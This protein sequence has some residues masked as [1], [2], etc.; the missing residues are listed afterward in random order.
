[1]DGRGDMLVKWI[2]LWEDSLVLVDL[3][4]G[5]RLLDQLEESRIDAVLAVQQSNRRF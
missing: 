2:H 4:E 1:V 3:E 5:D